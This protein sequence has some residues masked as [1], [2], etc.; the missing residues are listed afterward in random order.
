MILQ[1]NYFKEIF[2]KN[3]ENIIDIGLDIEGNSFKELLNY[4]GYGC[5]NINNNNSI[6]LLLLSFYFKDNYLFNKVMDYCIKNMDINITYGL[7]NHINDIDINEYDRIMNKCKEFVQL[8]GT[9]ILKNEKFMKLSIEGVEYIMQV[10][11]MVVDNEN[12]V[13]SKLIEYSIYNKDKIVKNQSFADKYNKLY[14]LVSWPN[15][16]FQQ[17]SDRDMDVVSQINDVDPNSVNDIVRIYLPLPDM[18][19]DKLAQIVKYYYIKED[20]EYSF[21]CILLFYY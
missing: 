14:L 9:S 17:L 13:L 10:K 2:N 11:R 6:D 3:N 1:N 12:L 16:D 21:K 4:Y 19:N 18:I 7:L 15:I 20:M 5:I 8:N